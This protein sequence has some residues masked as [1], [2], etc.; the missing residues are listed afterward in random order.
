MLMC[1][2]SI[3]YIT[4]SCVS[5]N[6]TFASLEMLHSREVDVVFGPICSTG[7]LCGFSDSKCSCTYVRFLETV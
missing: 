1:W 2:S 6:G 4:T 3:V 5:K 7:E